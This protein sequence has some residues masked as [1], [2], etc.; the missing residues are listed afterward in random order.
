MGGGPGRDGFPLSVSI[1]L[2]IEDA[3]IGRLSNS[4]FFLESRE[5]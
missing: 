1:H 3:Q 5:G 2:D 4:D